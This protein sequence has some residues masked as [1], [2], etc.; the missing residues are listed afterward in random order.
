MADDANFC[1]GQL[2][3]TTFLRVV[4]HDLPQRPSR[5][6]RRVPFAGEE[7]RRT[8][9]TEIRESD[10]VSLTPGSPKESP[11]LAA[12]GERDLP[13][14]PAPLE[15]NINESNAIPGRAF[16]EQRKSKVNKAR[17][18][19]KDT[20]AHPRRANEPRSAGHPRPSTTRKRRSPVQGLAL[21]RITDSNGL[22]DPVV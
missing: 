16:T 11:S 14:S 21:V 8:T 12:D 4:E 1:G 6:K 22:P 7:H 17:L 9:A 13:H 15:L 20:I 2:R 19:K 18:R 3:L 10:K 5:L